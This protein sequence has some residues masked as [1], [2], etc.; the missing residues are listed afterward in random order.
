MP[1]F[2]AYN[3]FLQSQEPHDHL[4]QDSTSNLHKALLSRFTRPDIITQSDDILCIDIEDST[5]YKEY[6]F[7]HI[8]FS[9]KQYAS[10][11]DL[12]GTS[13][14]TKFLR[15]AQEFYIRACS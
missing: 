6:S 14:Y 7:A 12:I 1:S 13:K 5:S 9:T 2:D 15:K 3:T 8:G 10:S 11:K 4:L